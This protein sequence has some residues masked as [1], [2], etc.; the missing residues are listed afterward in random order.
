MSVAS[1]TN[2]LTLAED[3]L[4]T[5][6]SHCGSFQ[7]LVGVSA[8]DDALSSIYIDDLPDKEDGSA[9]AEDELIDLSPYAVVT[10]S[11]EDGFIWSPG[12]AGVHVTGGTLVFLIERVVPKADTSR[13]IAF[14]NFKNIIGNIAEEIIEQGETP[15]RIIRPEVALTDGP[16]RDKPNKRTGTGDWMGAEF[17]VTWGSLAGEAG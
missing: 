3:Y 17:T 5:T 2:A 13:A 10:T 8:A 12:G 7:S 4:K 9:Y 6:I 15:G 16:W 11:Q 14:R 1:G